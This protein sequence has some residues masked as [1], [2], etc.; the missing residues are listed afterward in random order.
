MLAVDTPTR[1]RAVAPIL[2]NKRRIHPTPPN[3]PG[4]RPNL[5]PSLSSTHL[6]P[7]RNAMHPNTSITNITH[8]TSFQP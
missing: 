2:S 8:T 3:F 7:I 4:P 5:I 1:K 6:K